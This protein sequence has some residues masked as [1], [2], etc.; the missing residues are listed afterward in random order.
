V[1]DEIMELIET[2]KIGDQFKALF[3]DGRV[4]SA[5]TY[6]AAAPMCTKCNGSATLFAL[7]IISP[8]AETPA[9]FALSNM[10][11]R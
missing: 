1:C 5:G 10:S 2:T 6:V 3:T 9:V 8:R 7:P 4:A 11:C